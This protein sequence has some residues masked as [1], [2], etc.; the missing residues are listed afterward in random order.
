MTQKNKIL[1]FGLVYLVVCLSCREHPVMKFTEKQLTFSNNGHTIH[2]TQVFSKDNQWIVYDTRNSDTAI[3]STGSIEM[4]N[5]LTKEVKRLYQTAHQSEY[6]PGVG[7]ATFSPV[8]DTVIFIHGIRNADANRPYSMTRRTG[9]AIAIQHPQRAIF[10]DARNIYPPFTKGAL[11]GGTHAHSWSGDGQWISF[12]YNDYVIEQR[13]KTHTNVQDLR[14]VGV[15]MPGLVNVMEDSAGENNKGEMF[16]AVVTAVVEDPRPG[17]DE[18]DKAFDECWIGKDGYLQADGHRQ[19][20]AIAFQG[21][22]RNTEGKTV[23]EVFVLD[24]P[25]DLSVPEISEEPLQGRPDKRPGVPKGVKQRRLTY[26]KKG[27]VGPRHWL[28]SAPDGNLIAFLST[29]E[30][31]VVQL[32]GVSPNG[33]KIKALTHHPFAIQGPFNFSPDGKYIAYPADN[34]IFITSIE[35]GESQRITSKFGEAEKPIG[36]PNWS[37]D[38]RMIAYNRYV[39]QKE[40]SFLQ[41]FLLTK[42]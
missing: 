18:I 34:S 20:R 28:R 11:R 5:T 39:A 32:F 24:L 8:S 16:A 38:G 22:V 42:D 31:G 12:T 9:V 7:A 14:T 6:G 3:A 33:G 21:N 27:I 29:D 17:S 1:L 19:R 15:M 30:E 10:M 37:A 25:S 35:T 4:I 41:V 13:A 40:G 2:N 36:A 26:T 23:A